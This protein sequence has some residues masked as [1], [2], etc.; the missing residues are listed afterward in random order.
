MRPSDDQLT[1]W[2]RA[3]FAGRASSETIAA[4]SEEVRRA[5]AAEVNAL[6]RLAHVSQER[7]QRLA[8]SSPCSGHSGTW[9]ECREPTC[10]GDRELVTGTDNHQRGEHHEE[11]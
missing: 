1:A 6:G 3:V 11:T 10:Q 7:H 5:R 4:I 9:A 2:M 8:I